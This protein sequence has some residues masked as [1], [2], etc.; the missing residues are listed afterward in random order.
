[1]ADLHRF[2]VAPDALRGDPV[3]I[4]GEVVHHL[5]TVLRLA[6]GAELLLLDGEGHCCRARLTA[7]GRERA[8]ATVTARWHETENPCPLRLLQ[9]LPKGDK[10]DLVLQKG[11]ELGVTVFQPLISERT[12]IRPAATRPERWQRIVGE[13]ARQSRRPL[14]PRLEPPRPLEDALQAVAEPLRLALWEEGARP[15]REL[16]PASPPAGLAVLVGPE[17][18]LAAKEV[19]AAE[20][21]GFVPV[22]LGPRI[23]RTETT[24]LAVAAIV[25]YLYG[26]WQ[27]APRPEHP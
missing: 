24:G 13:A 10:F 22:H 1:M 7:V 4:A 8:T 9:A 2:F 26:D 18:G 14:L 21:A 17:G 19:E 16:L 25:Q 6:P 15:L 27:Q 11:T 20:R 5:R 3:E 23:L 12:T